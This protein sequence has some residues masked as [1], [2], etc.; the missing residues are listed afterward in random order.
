MSA[1]K[2]LK[3]LLVQQLKQRLSKV[4]QD[5]E[6]VSKPPP[7]LKIVSYG[8]IIGYIDIVTEKEIS[9]DRIAEWK[10]LVSQGNKLTIIIPKE[11]KLKI[12]ETLWKEG[13]AEKV[14]VGTYEINLFLP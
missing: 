13:L 10:N 4:K 12:T 1:G 14:S 6:S 9:S 7:D 5:L 11:E 3:E 2:Y 8:M